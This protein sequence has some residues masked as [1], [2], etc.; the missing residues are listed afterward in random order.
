M[1]YPLD[2]D[3]ISDEKLLGELQRRASL[4]IRGLC[5]YCERPGKTSTCKFPDRHAQAV[6]PK[7]P[8][9]GKTIWDHLAAETEAE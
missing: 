9:N 6:E 5:T 2:L 1:G 3:E 7:T 8:P 4:R